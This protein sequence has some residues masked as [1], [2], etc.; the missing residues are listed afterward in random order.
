VESVL[1]GHEKGA[2]TGADRTQE[3]LIQLADGGTLFLDEVGELRLNIQKTFLRVL[4]EHRFRSV[5]GKKEI[6]SN[7]RLI[8]ATNRHLEQMVQK[9]DFRPDLWHRL[10]SL[11]IHLPPLRERKM[12]IR[13]LAMVFMN[14]FCDR[15]NKATKGI[16]P[17]FLEA[18]QAYDWPGN[19]RELEN[20]LNSA[21]TTAGE[22]PVLFAKHL[23]LHIRVKVT[24][25]S[26]KKEVPVL[27][28]SPEDLNQNQTLG[29][30]KEHRET[31]LKEAEKKY[32]Q[33]L[34]SFTQGDLDKAC[35]VSDL[36]KSHLYALLKKHKKG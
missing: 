1:F 15:N 29:T 35:L 20:S 11:V 12:D 34:M 5:G 19:V 22:D 31:I 23:P 17:E 16:S 21:V 3:G 13:E 28:Q 36:S 14:R 25:D 30:F 24:Q 2:F 32:F 18:L 26:V 27:P 7:F 10:Q 8:A 33:D 6:K 9:G 4:Q